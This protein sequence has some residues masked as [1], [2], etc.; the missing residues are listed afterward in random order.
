MV[1]TLEMLFNGEDGGLWSKEMVQ[2]VVCLCFMFMAPSLFWLSVILVAVHWSYTGGSALTLESSALTICA[3]ST[4]ILVIH[5]SS[6]SATSR[7]LVVRHTSGSAL[8][9]IRSH[10]G[11]SATTSTIAVTAELNIRRRWRREGGS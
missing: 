9:S 5:H 7:V 6:G 3:S 4:S 10:T 2:L 11:G 1:T 8:Q